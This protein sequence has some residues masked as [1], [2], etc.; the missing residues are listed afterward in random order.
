MHNGENMRGAKNVNH[1]KRNLNKNRGKFVN[2]GEI[3]EE[4]VNFVEINGNSKMHHWL[5]GNGRLCSPAISPP[6]C[7]PNPVPIPHASYNPSPSLLLIHS[8]LPIPHLSISHSFFSHPLSTLPLCHPLPTS[9]LPSFLLPLHFFP[10]P[11]PDPTC[12]SPFLVPTRC[13]PLLCFPHV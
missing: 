8:H 1:A 2:F 7:P 12:L 5:M 11:L 10:H 13:S 6:I 9:F 4:F 3:G